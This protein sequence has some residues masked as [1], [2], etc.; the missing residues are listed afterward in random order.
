VAHREG[1]VIAWLLATAHAA[2]LVRARA[3]AA[4]LD[5][6][7]WVGVHFAIADGWHLYWENPGDSGM[8][9]RFELE[10]AAAP[11]LFPGPHRFV[12]P[13]DVVNYGYEGE[14][15]VLFRGE[16]DEIDVTWLVCRSECV[17]GSAH[18]VVPDP[19]RSDRRAI[20]AARKALPDRLP[21]PADGVLALRVEPG[22][23]VTV[24]PSVGAEE[25]VLVAAVEGRTLHF[26]ADPASVLAEHGVVLQLAGPGGTRYVQLGPTMEPR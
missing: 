4:R 24:F 11:P 21:V 14:A 12:L 9:T 3:L 19:R 20:R 8:P 15:T 2:D 25:A 23:A 17:P 18:L 10:G 6:E 26:R 7:V 16:P 22:T 5:G 13:G 1:A